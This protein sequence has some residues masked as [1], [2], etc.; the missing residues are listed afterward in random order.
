MVGAA[1][2]GKLMEAGRVKTERYMQGVFVVAALCLSVP[3]IVPPIKEPMRC[4]PVNGDG[5]QA[6]RSLGSCLE[7]PVLSHPRKARS[8]KL[9]G[10]T[11]A[12]AIPP[13][14]RNGLSYAG[15]MHLLAFCGFELCVGMF[16]P[17]MMTMRR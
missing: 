6:W 1:L 4:V 9:V 16:W 3:V 12:S 8:R 11:G 17:S 5:R 2:A 7:C 10:L 15:K 13:L 14:S